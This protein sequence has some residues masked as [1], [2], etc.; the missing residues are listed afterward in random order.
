MCERMTLRLA[1]TAL[2][3]APRGDGHPVLILPGFMTSD[4]STRS[5]R[6]YLEKIGYDPHAWALGRNLGPRA[7][8]REGEKLLARLDAIHEICGQKVTLIGWSLGGVLARQVSR[9]RPELVR[10]IITLASPFTGDPTACNIASTYQLITGQ[11]IQEKSVQALLREGR[12][13]PPVPSTAIYSKADGIVAW[14]N[15]VEPEAETTDN[16][17][18]C[19]SH[20]GLVFNPAVLYA[21]ADR[22]ALPE[23]EWRPFE[24]KGLRM[25]VYPSSGHV[26]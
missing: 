4:R 2:L 26:H 18:V 19:G 24:R 17:E 14:Q 9:Q 8:G 15:C 7:V 21:I 12:E 10:Q 22:L 5:L 23:G 25:F 3:N 6:S 13:P 16:I 1:S 20:C 11:H